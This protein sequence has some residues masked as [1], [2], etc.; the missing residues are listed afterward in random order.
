MAITA[1]QPWPI[2]DIADRIHLTL[3]AKA[4]TFGLCLLPNTISGEQWVFTLSGNQS[5][6][7]KTGSAR[8]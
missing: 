7:R 4:I 8:R 5:H 1:L 6:E 2:T 3:V